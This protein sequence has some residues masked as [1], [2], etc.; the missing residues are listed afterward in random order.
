MKLSALIETLQKKWTSLAATRMGLCSPLVAAT[1]AM[2][3][4]AWSLGRQRI[5]ALIRAKRLGR[6]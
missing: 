6:S 1:T 3:L 4:L 2:M 5:G